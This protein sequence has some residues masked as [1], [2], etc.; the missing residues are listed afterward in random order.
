M[1]PSI[2][3]D[4]GGTKVLAAVVDGLG[5][6]LDTEA[7]A[8]PGPGSGVDDA[9]VEEVEDALVEVVERLISQHGRLTVGVAAAGF[10]ARDGERVR[11]APHLP[12]RD[13]PLA[14]RLG[15]RLGH[16]A[17]GRVLVD[18]D[19][20]AALWAE[21]RFGAAQD[22]LDAVMITLGTGI[23]GAL[24]GRG[25]MLRGTNGMAGEFGHMQVVPDGLE[26]ECGRRGCWEQYCSGRALARAAAEHGSTLTGPALTTAAR[27]GDAAAA[28][29]YAEVGR[30]LGVGMANLAAALDPPLIV[31]G[32]GVSAGG[33]LLLAP[34]RE[35]LAGSLVGVGHRDLPEVVG[36]VLGP[37]AGVVG[38][39]DL[40]RVASRPSRVGRWGRAP[41]RVARGRAR[42]R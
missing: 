4:I 41:S 23:G 32:G 16:R 36:A 34:A 2:G 6:V 29:A 21:A 33:D 30:W 10:V 24:V 15:K 11:F 8:T 38:A 35:A 28:A 40:A 9:T 42:R 27:E 19:A 39:A 14:E 20:N 25:M 26:C 3:V 31:V 17:V 1:L 18:N 7:T 22:S 5:R 13:E 12:W 37:L